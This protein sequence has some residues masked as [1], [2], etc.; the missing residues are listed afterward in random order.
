MVLLYQFLLRYKDFFNQWK[1]YI[2]SAIVSFILLAGFIFWR[3]DHQLQNNKVNNNDASFKQL[4]TDN[5]NIKLVEGQ[6]KDGDKRTKNKGPVYV[7]IKGAI[8]HPNV[9]KMSSADRVIDLLNKAELLEDADVSQI[10][11]SEKLTD[12][13]MIYIPHKG[14][15]N[16]ESQLGTNKL[17]VNQSNTSVKVN[18]NTASASE[19]M[20]VPGVGQTK[21]NA[22][23]EH[24][25]QQGAFQDIE[26]LKK[27]KGFGS[28]T[29]EKLKSY[30]TI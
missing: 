17:Q 15:K 25:N 8:K 19:L 26:E 7:D 20:S 5:N 12:Q 21:A 28:K 9:Y 11:L 6:N 29:F 27:V 18:L 2:I 4:N 24:R 23:I 3:Q 1:V 22:I 30:F 10:N 13:K 16:I 14:Q